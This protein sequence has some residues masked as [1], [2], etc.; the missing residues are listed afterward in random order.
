MQYM[1]QYVFGHIHYDGICISFKRHWLLYQTVSIKQADPPALG[2]LGCLDTAVSF[3]RNRRKYVFIL[4]HQ[5]GYL[6][7]QRLHV[8]LQE[9]C[10]ALS[11]WGGFCKNEASKM[12]SLQGGSPMGHT[13]AGTVSLGVKSSKMFRAKWS[14][15]SAL[16]RIAVINKWL[17]LMLEISVQCVSPVAFSSAFSWEFGVPWW[18]LFS[19]EQRD[20]YFMH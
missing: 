7:V 14:C 3:F 20:Q 10:K 4:C 16:S 9:G 15:L 18:A 19:W 17:F 8:L 13:M 11:L 5:W 6:A 2:V 12:W 1:K